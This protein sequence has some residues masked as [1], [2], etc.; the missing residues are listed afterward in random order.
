MVEVN[1]VGGLELVEW[2][3]IEGAVHATDDELGDAHCQ[4]DTLEYLV[5]VDPQADLQC[6][7]C[8]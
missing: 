8:Q 4:C 5:P 2:H 3:V 1:V 7:S 6:D